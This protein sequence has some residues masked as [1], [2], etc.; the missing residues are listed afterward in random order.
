MI[1]NLYIENFKCFDAINIP[2]GYLS[3]LTGFNA[4]GK[5]TT[6]QALLLLSQMANQRRN[7]V[8]APLNGDLVSLG[9]AG[10][11]MGKGESS[12]FKVGVKTHTVAVEWTFTPTVDSE[13]GHSLTLVNLEWSYPESDEKEVLQVDA[14]TK[15]SGLVPECAP[16]ELLEVAKNLSELIY[17]SAIRVG[18]QDVYP[19][20]S[21]SDPVW[22]DVGTK[23]EF[24]AWWFEKKLDTTISKRLLHPSETATTLRRQLN[25]WA[26]ELF[27]GAEAN[28]QKL[29]DTDLIQLSFRNNG[30]GVWR[31]PAN[32][33]YGL[34]YAFSI[35]VAGLLAKPGQ[36]LVIDS[37]EAH[38]HPMGQSNIGRF[39][40]IVAATGVQIL[41]ETHSDHVLN[42]ARLAVKNNRINA[43]DLEILFFNRPPIDSND[44]A[45][46][47]LPKV[48]KDG[49][50]SEWPEG[51][52]DQAESDLATLAG[53]S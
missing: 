16:K 28:A 8:T 41:L 21:L 47:V 52:F 53:W 9:S 22:G 50:L 35:L 12:K 26:G 25:A 44:P 33:G 37:P 20:P 2:L 42:G 32:I 34:T 31:K 48:N 14:S 11:I 30:T 46:V 51:F 29:G 36:I 6:L 39:L 17:I 40:A 27:P 23:G 43:G 13:A 49:N 3:L 5:S 45:H 24:A 7:G 15:F 10:D 4:A 19:S 18:P 1:K 38:L